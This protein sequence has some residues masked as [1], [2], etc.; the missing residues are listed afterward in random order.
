MAQPL[1]LPV[2]KGPV[3]VGDLNKP[4]PLRRQ[5]SRQMA[6]IEE[7]GNTACLQNQELDKMPIV[8]GSSDQ[9]QLMSSGHLC[10]PGVQESDVSQSAQAE[11]S[12]N[13]NNNAASDGEKGRQTETEAAGLHGDVSDSQKSR[14]IVSRIREIRQTVAP[15][16]GFQRQLTA[17]SENHGANGEQSSA[18]KVT[19]AAEDVQ[20]MKAPS[21]GY[22][23]QWSAPAGDTSSHRP[24]T[25]SS[26]RALDRRRHHTDGPALDIRSASCVK[27]L[28]QASSGFRRQVSAPAGAG[29]DG[30][31]LS[32]DQWEK[33]GNL[34]DTRVA[35][36]TDA[37]SVLRRRR[38]S[39]SAVNDHCEFVSHN[40]SQF[41]FHGKQETQ[42]PA[43][44]SLDEQILSDVFQQCC[45]DPK[46]GKFPQC[47]GQGVRSSTPQSSNGDCSQLKL[48]SSSLEELLG[49]S[50]AASPTTHSLSLSLSSRDT[51]IMRKREMKF[52]KCS[53]ATTDGQEEDVTFMSSD[54]GK[55]ILILSVLQKDVSV[56]LKKMGSGT[57]D[58]IYE[59]GRQLGV[60]LTATELHD[61]PPA[62]RYSVPE[63]VEISC[64]PLSRRPPFRWDQ[65]S[66]RHPG[67]CFT[68]VPRYFEPSD[69]HRP[70]WK[71]GVGEQDTSRQPE[72]C[73]GGFSRSPE[74]S[75]QSKDEHFE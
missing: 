36:D 69:Y 3:R 29:E 4:R 41:Q 66:Q 15:L 47:Y 32:G 60:S 46:E 72:R 59:I 62:G 51:S 30:T 26:G 31:S 53:V 37:N 16:P 11:R 68:E 45:S 18:D 27:E 1:N 7:A 5:T 49:M 43:V 55:L 44:S 35:N 22:Q 58:L 75:L 28:Q 40:S 73:R 21:S 13:R 10:S 57:E 34:T 42:V 39:D 67:I 20:Q 63:L 50:G 25:A 2:M 74:Q 54:T 23:R 64:H 19:I 61:L 24:E 14:R 65:L 17:P 56:K 8:D 9:F 38:R 71:D 12:P 6:V 33:H 70:Q 52:V 48:S